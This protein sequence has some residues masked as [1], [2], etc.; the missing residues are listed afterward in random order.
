MSLDREAIHLYMIG[1]R[2]DKLDPN[3]VWDILHKV[4]IEDKVFEI[5]SFPSVLNI[6][7]GEF[8]DVMYNTASHFTVKI[9]DGFEKWAN[10]S[11]SNNNST[12]AQATYNQSSGMLSI[13]NKHVKIR[14]DSFRA[15]LLV[16]LFKNKSSRNKEWSWDE[17]IA[18]I[19]GINVNDTQTLKANKKKFYPACDGLS[20]HIASKIGVNDLLIFNKSSVRINRKYV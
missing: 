5:I 7:L 8:E 10:K 1:N 3:E 12:T 13:D 9:N 17:I 19:E 20:K 18:Q 15:N 2:L 6:R 14:K 4:E 11:S 16:L